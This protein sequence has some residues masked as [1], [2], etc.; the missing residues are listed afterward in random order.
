VTAYSALRT[1]LLRRVNTPS[2]KQITS[3][4]AGT[5][6]NNALEDWTNS[7]E[8]LWRPYGFYITA[9]QFR[10][11]LPSDWVKPKTAHWYQNGHKP[12]VYLS[13]KD[14][15]RRGYLDWNQ[16]VSSPEAYT[17]IDNCL[18]L[19]PP[20]S[21][22]GN[23]ST[24]NGTHN[25]TVTTIA[26]GD[27]TQFHTN[28]GMI[29][30]ENEQILHQGISSNNLTLAVRGQAGTTAAAHTP[31]TGT[32]TVYRLDLIVNYFYVPAAL[33]SDTAE[34]AIPQRWHKTLLHHAIANALYQLGREVEAGQQMAIYEAKKK[35]A[36]AEMRRVQRDEYFSIYSPYV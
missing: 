33:S 13:P 32:I 2:G 22:S 3:A 8:P 29:L 36:K 16:T 7:V 24:L 14:F 28:G 17:I 1:E 20:P 26:V 10:Y 6:I 5:Y 27:G 31:G 25:S 34:P 15:Q 23:T 12:L 35:E 11:A 9:N 4:V 18:Y 30:V 19:G 21:T